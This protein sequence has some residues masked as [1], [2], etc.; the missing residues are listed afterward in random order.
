M[1]CNNHL[2]FI[3][4]FPFASTTIILP[5]STTYRLSF[6]MMHWLSAAMLIGLFISGLFIEGL[7]YYSS[8]YQRLPMLH[9][10]FGLLLVPLTIIRFASRRQQPKF[11]H[12][13]G[14]RHVYLLIYS[15]LSILFISGYLISSEGG[16]VSIF[17]LFSLPELVVFANQA[18]VIGALHEWVAYI[19]AIVVL[20]HIAAALWHHFFKKD[21][22]LR[23]MI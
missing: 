3:A 4:V 8:W 6:R 15:L 14:V 5:M 10:G 2:F 12:L 1:L 21:D 20:L 19:L 16:S 23:R 11:K 7:S 9:I 18:Q 22:T 13:M 17:G